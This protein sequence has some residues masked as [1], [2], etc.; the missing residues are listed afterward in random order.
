MIKYKVISSV[1]T[2]YYTVGIGVDRSVICFN[3]FLTG[4]AYLLTYWY[5]F[6]Y[7]RLHYDQRLSLP[8]YYQQDNPWPI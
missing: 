3:S 7:K 2:L 8:K 4:L 1:M 6:S 5:G